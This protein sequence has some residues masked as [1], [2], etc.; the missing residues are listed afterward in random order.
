MVTIKKNQFIINL[1]NFS[2]YIIKSSKLQQYWTPTLFQH[3]ISTLCYCNLS[4]INRTR[5][6]QCDRKIKNGRAEN[7]SRLELLFSN[8]RSNSSFVYCLFL[9]SLT[10]HSKL[11][12]ANQNFNYEQVFQS[13]CDYS[14]S[15]SNTTHKLILILTPRKVV[16]E[17]THKI[18]E[19]FI[20]IS[21]SKL[22]MHR[23]WTKV[24]LLQLLASYLRVQVVTVR[25]SFLQKLQ[26]YLLV[27]MAKSIPP[28]YF[29]QF[30]CCC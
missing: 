4:V 14:E 20:S 6:I 26:H 27:C 16:P 12:K 30:S 25:S 1:V 13:I 21:I 5:R 11:L 19:H 10:V 23:K 7:N 17:Q 18:V 29:N 9:Y 3:S 28:L 15:S 2:K 22:Q 24:I 8:E